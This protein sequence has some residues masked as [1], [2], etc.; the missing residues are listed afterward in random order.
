M[1][2]YT[3]TELTKS[4][5]KKT[6]E[7]NIKADFPETL[8][9]KYLWSIFRHINLPRLLATMLISIIVTHTSMITVICVQRYSAILCKSSITW[10]YR[11][12]FLKIDNQILTISTVSSVS[13]KQVERKIDCMDDNDYSKNLS[14]ATCPKREF[15]PNEVLSSLPVSEDSCCK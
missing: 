15:H 1:K 8:N 11:Y 2:Q 14:F 9:K 13:Q 5:S 7:L 10:I 12:K 4:S 6:P 3:R